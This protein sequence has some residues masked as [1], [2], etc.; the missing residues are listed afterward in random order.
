MTDE[1]RYTAQEVADL[2][3]KDGRGIIANIVQSVLT[4]NPYAEAEG[5]VAGQ[6]FSDAYGQLWEFYPANYCG[7]EP[8]EPPV[9]N[10]FGDANTYDFD[11]PVRPL[12]GVT[13]GTDSEVLAGLADLIEAYDSNESLC[14]SGFVITGVRKL[15]NE[16]G[17][18]PPQ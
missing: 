6:V 10:A 5:W 2:L 14:S 17:K 15:I 12:F 1:K 4:P 3:R 11:V 8:D 16:Y 7:E 9:W 13:I 18:L